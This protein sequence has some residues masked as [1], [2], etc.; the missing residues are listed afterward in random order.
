MI[1]AMLLVIL[2]VTGIVRALSGGDPVNGVFAVLWLLLAAV[3]LGDIVV[4]RRRQ[5]AAPGP[6]TTPEEDPHVR[7]R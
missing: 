4:R 1:L 5:S 6:H 7:S 3:T 2:A